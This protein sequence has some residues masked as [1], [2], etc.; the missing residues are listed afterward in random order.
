MSSI[1]FINILL[2]LLF[3]FPYEAFSFS[4]V[5]ICAPDH[6]Q[7]YNSDFA[8]KIRDELMKKVFRDEFAD[9]S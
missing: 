7:R 1:T 3:F 9:K 5:V 8:S 2:T 6:L 4:A